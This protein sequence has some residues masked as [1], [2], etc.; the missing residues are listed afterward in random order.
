MGAAYSSLGQTKILYATP[1]VLLDEKAK[2]L[3][4]VP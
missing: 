2:F 1:L 4:R 3:Q